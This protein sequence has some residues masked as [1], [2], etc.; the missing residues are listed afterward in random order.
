MNRIVEMM[1][2]IVHKRCWTWPY[3]A[4][5]IVD[6]HAYVISIV[7]RVEE[8]SLDQNIVP[9]IYLSA[10]I[11]NNLFTMGN[12]CIY[13][14]QRVLFTD[15]NSYWTIWLVSYIAYVLLISSIVPPK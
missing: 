6:K 5:T 15:K 4:Q 9:F 10:T 12:Y 2:L 13:R 11:I 3:N 14:V 8:Q 1:Y 7:I